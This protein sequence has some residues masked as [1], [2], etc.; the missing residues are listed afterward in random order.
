MGLDASELQAYQ[1]LI[2]HLKKKSFLKLTSM[3]KLTYNYIIY[4]II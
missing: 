1:E 4:I 3:I 2:K